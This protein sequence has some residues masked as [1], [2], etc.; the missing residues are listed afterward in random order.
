MR[1]DYRWREVPLSTAKLPG[2]ENAGDIGDAGETVVSQ[3]AMVFLFTA[4]YLGAWATLGFAAIRQAKAAAFWRF[5]NPVPY[6]LIVFTAFPLWYFFGYLISPTYSEFRAGCANDTELNVVRPYPTRKTYSLLCHEVRQAVF[7]GQYDEG[8]C[9]RDLA[10]KAVL[11]RRALPA[12][13]ECD[14]PQ[15][16]ACFS[17]EPTVLPSFAYKTVTGVI[18]ETDSRLFADSMVTQQIDFV[19]QTGK[20]L[21]YYRTYHHFPHGRLSTLTGLLTGRHDSLC[22]YD[23]YGDDRMR[24]MYPPER[25][26]LPR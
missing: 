6:L 5:S 2:V 11:I 18:K 24:K 16:N 15:N 26:A 9:L 13:S 8:V 22:T 3:L 14:G 7:D 1:Y 23:G 12:S 19:D 17:I 4:V 25:L 20:L 10:E 21:A